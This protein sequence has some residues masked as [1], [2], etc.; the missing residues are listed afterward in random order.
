MTSLHEITY[1]TNALYRR[2]CDEGMGDNLRALNER[3]EAM[4]GKKTH[5]QTIPLNRGNLERAAQ[6]ARR[7]ASELD[8]ILTLK[9]TDEFGD[10]VTAKQSLSD[11]L[12]ELGE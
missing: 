9:G 10:P 8:T 4:A 7:A 5:T 6:L 12:T 2:L 3:I 1:R 11:A